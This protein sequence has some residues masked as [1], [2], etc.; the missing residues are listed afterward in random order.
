M[1]TVRPNYVMLVF[2]ITLLCVFFYLMSIITRNYQAGKYEN[3]PSIVYWG[4]VAFSLF[5]TYL[6][7]S[8][9]CIF[10]IQYFEDE[11]LIRFSNLLGGKRTVTTSEI[12]GYYQATFKTR[13][14]NYGGYIF[15]LNNGKTIEIPEYNSSRLRNFYSFIVNAG[16]PCLGT[17]ISWYPLK[18]KL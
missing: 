10:K 6:I 16:I 17:K 1:E 9:F 12:D 11:R 7:W 3:K 8:L 14:K 5:P 18:R 13:L 4:M 15:K 2:R